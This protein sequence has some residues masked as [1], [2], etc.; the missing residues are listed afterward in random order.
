M[1]LAIGSVQDLV[2]YKAVISSWVN[3]ATLKLGKKTITYNYTSPQGCSGSASKTTIVADT[4]GN[5]CSVTKYD[6]VKVVNTITKYDTIT[7]KITVND[8]VGILKLKFKLTTGMQA[9]QIASMTLY[10]NPTTNVLHIEVGDA[11]ALEGY[12]Y[13]I[14]DA[15]GKVIYNEIVKNSITEIPLMSLGAAGMYQ[16]EVLDQKN[17]TIQTHVEDYQLANMKL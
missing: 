3:P 1:I 16:F 9:N 13:R 4:V 15:L 14:L 11:K 12:R 7:T 17:T 6:T 5:V 8:T 2:E 10:P